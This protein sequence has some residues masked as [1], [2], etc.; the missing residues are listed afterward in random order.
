MQT[1][2]VCGGR[3]TRLQPR[4]VAAKTLVRIGHS[5]L[6]ER[7]VRW[8]APLHCSAAPPIVIVDA[9]DRETPAVVASLLPSAVVVRQPQP[10]G[11]ANALLLASPVLAECAIVMLGDVFVDGV[12][13]TIPAG[14]ALT[15]WPNASPIET[16]K[17]FGIAVDSSGIAT[18][19]IEKPAACEALRCGMGVY[20]FTRDIISCFRDA[21]I[22][23][24]TGERGITRAIQAAIDAGVRFRTLAFGGYYN[25]VNSPADVIAVENHLAQSGVVGHAT[26]AAC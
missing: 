9:H 4:S 3:G 19:V 22:D 7:L 16:H 12:V 24:V 5:T 10:D 20:V 13:P 6:L 14:P 23:R 15:F 8:V 2:F 18:D 1:V 21:P 25:N 26:A 11:V 17:N